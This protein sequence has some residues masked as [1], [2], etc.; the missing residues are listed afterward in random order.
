MGVMV[1]EVAGLIRNESWGEVGGVREGCFWKIDLDIQ[2]FLH[3][4]LRYKLPDY[5]MV[6]MIQHFNIFTFFVTDYT[7]RERER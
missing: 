1:T 3:I 6:V 7:R 4:K 5:P 2:R